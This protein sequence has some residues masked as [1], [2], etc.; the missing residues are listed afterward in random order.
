MQRFAV[1]VDA[2]Y[3]LAAGGWAVT[4]SPRRSDSIARSTAL[5]AWLQARSQAALP[6]RELLRL[7]WYDAAPNRQATTDQLVIAELPDTK[8]RLG[9]L[10][11]QGTQKGVDALL[12]SDLTTLS[13]ERSIDTAILIAGDGDFAE[14]VNQ[15]QQHGTRLLL[16]AIDTPQ[17]TVSPVL[18]HEADRVELIGSAEL[19]EYFTAAPPKPVRVPEPVTPRPAAATND[20]PVY[21]TLVTDEALRIGR[22]FADRW[23]AQ[24]TDGDRSA[25][26]AGEPRVPGEI[27]YRLIRFALEEAN[28]SGD[29]RLAPDALRTIREGFWAGL[30]AR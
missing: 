3:L 23:S 5:V 24:V 7:Y 13:R 28:L 20:L 9:H 19:V 6:E 10:T 11:S 12:L 4:G 1:F 22:A 27:D 21:A 16:W 8:L 15:S 26:M 30:A 17:N 2:G 25:V 18:R 29:T 14:A